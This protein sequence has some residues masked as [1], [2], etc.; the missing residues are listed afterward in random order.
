MTSED[1]RPR[2]KVVVG[3]SLTVWREPMGAE[4]RENKMFFFFSGPLHIHGH[5]TLAVQG[6]PHY[7]GGF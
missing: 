6:Q 3:T 4:D 1:L 2:E 5:L 7:K